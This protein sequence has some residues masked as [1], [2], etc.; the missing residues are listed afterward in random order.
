MQCKSSIENWSKI[1]VLVVKCILSLKVKLLINLLMHSCV[2][3]YVIV[4]IG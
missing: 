4:V 1:E 3:Q 2:K